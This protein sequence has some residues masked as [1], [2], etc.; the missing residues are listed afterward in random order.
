MFHAYKILHVKKSNLDAP[1]TMK[2]PRNMPKM[3]P[4]ND[5]SCPKVITG[6]IGC[7]STATKHMEAS[8]N[9]AYEVNPTQ[10][11]WNNEV[12]LS[13]STNIN[14]LISCT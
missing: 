5:I 9:P 2:P 7:K 4:Q 3:S 11:E 14:L 8:L 13:F 10:S 1:E 12:K 6:N